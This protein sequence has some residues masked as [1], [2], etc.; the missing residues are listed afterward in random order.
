MK[1]LEE[2]LT[3]FVFFIQ[4]TGENYSLKINKL[5]KWQIFIAKLKIFIIKSWQ[6]LV[7]KKLYKVL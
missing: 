1:K 2:K 3:I 6:S 4:W 7:V 5:A